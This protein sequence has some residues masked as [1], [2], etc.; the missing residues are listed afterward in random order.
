MVPQQQKLEIRLRKRPNTRHKRVTVRVRDKIQT[1]RHR[2][3]WW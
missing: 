1:Y 2:D 3:R